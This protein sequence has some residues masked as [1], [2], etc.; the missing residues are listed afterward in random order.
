MGLAGTLTE[1][2]R[3]DLREPAGWDAVSTAA[4]AITP[5]GGLGDRA[6]V[7]DTY[8]TEI[9]TLRDRIRTQTDLTIELPE[10]IAVCDRHDWL[11][12]MGQL[13]GR[14]AG[15]DAGAALLGG[16]TPVA[17]GGYAGMLGLLS[18]RVLGQVDPGLLAAGGL[19]GL[20]IVEPN[21]QA[22]ARR[23]EAEPAVLRRWI[24]AHELVH[25]AQFSSAPWLIGLLEQQ[26]AAVLRT[27]ASGRLDA[28]ALAQLQRVM[29][30][31]EGHA[32]WQMDALLDED[33][34]ALRAAI[35]RRR[36]APDPLTRVLGALIGLD[37]KLT[38]YVTGRA[39][40]AA[41]AEGPRAVRPTRVFD[42]PALLPTESELAAPQR[43]VA[44]VSA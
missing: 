4:A 42:E 23:L 38:Q 3:A 40:F 35:D 13:L 33:V 24:L 11:A 30:V 9:G 22:T 25:V 34:S 10:T 7:A 8:R 28:E 43:W 17:A 12:M 16:P 32:E 18:R 39:F 27:A 21:L 15:S 26:L 2:G 44:R 6:A 1:L 37:Q 41:V 14:I 20:Y 5:A 29:T 19:R 31:I 36:R